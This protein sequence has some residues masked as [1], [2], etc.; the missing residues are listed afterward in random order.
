MPRYIRTQDLRV[1]CLQAIPIT[2]QRQA[3]KFGDM[4]SFGMAETATLWLTIRQQANFLYSFKVF[5][6]LKIG[7][8]KESFQLNSS[9]NLKMLVHVT[10]N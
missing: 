3:T 7:Y 6:R 8:E 9:H 2:L 1:N 10:L 5:T 4:N